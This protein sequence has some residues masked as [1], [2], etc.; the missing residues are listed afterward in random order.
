MKSIRYYLSAFLLAGGLLTLGSCN[1]IFDDLASNPNQPSLD[2]YFKDASAVNDAVLSLYGYISTQRCLGASGSKTVIMR[3][4]EASTNSDYGKPGMYGADLNSSYYTIEQPFT[5]MYTI[6]S[7][8]SFV[9]EKIAEVDFSANETQRDAY[10]GEAYFWRA[11]AHF[12][13][14]TNYRQVTPVRHMPQT[15]ADYVRPVE[16][17]AEVWNFIQEDLAEAEKLLP[18][19]GYWAA[20]SAGRV[21]KASAAAMLGKAYLYR[22]GIETHYGDDHTTYYAEAAAAFGRIIS[23]QYGQYSLAPRYADNFDT[24]H[25]NNDESILE[26]QF[27]GDVN[28][29]GFNPGTATSGLAFDG[30]GLMLP[31][32]GVGY[33]GVAHNWLYDAYAAS[34]DKDG[35]TDCRMFATLMFDDTAPEIRLPRDA[36]GHPVR[37]TGPGGYT[38][39]QLY[40]AKDGATGFATVANKLAHPFKAGIKKGLDYSM[41]TQTAEDGSPKLIGVGAGVKE[42]LYNQP[43]AHGVNWRYIRYADVLLMYAEACLEGAAPAGTLSPLEAVNLVR[44]RAN[45]EDLKQLTMAALKRERILE[46]A[47]EGHRFYDLLRWGELKERFDYLQAKDPNFKKFISADDFKG[48]TAHKNEWLPIPITE[49]D[50]NPYLSENNPG[51]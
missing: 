42:Y 2:A 23:G 32:A 51:Y 41:P 44:R 7:Q 39:E 16:R 31:G 14:L 1:D 25:E 34:V 49:M 38:W 3:S 18:A 13:L 35:C 19:K 45:L 33:E 15:A 24:S 28:N 47:L 37:Q 50:S 22:S 8:A 4:D 17:P 10:L 6:A 48:F 29:A 36:S 21:T 20:E 26:F 12:Y 9:I 5:L 30:R 11:F 27:L 46:L 43:R 40:P